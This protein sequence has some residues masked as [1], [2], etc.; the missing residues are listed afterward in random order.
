MQGS[1]AARRQKGGK[2][3]EDDLEPQGY[4]IASER[5]ICDDLEGG[6]VMTLDCR[7]RRVCHS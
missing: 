4:R 3:R 6:R 5:P 1:Y 2:R 7:S